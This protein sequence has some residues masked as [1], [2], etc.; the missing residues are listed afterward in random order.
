MKYL[1][2]SSTLFPLHHTRVVSLK[3]SGSG[4][5]GLCVCSA[6]LNKE[7]AQ[8]ADC[9][10]LKSSSW[11]VC[12][13]WIQQLVWTRKTNPVPGGAGVTQELSQCTLEGPFRGCQ[14]GFFSE[15]GAKFLRIVH[16]HLVE[17]PG[18]L[19]WTF[20]SKTAH[21]AAVWCCCLWQMNYLRTLRMV[22]HDRLYSRFSLLE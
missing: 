1:C 2:L 18:D 4:G 7:I 22:S 19:F 17:K 11:W 8:F 12:L 10:K 13:G 15:P 21:A 3:H 16:Y 9:H 20:F 6:G 14:D 5:W